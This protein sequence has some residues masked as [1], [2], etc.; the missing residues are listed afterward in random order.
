MNKVKTITTTI[1]WHEHPKLEELEK[2][3]RDKLPWDLPQDFAEKA[4]KDCES[5]NEF[6]Y[7]AIRWIGEQ[8]VLLTE[9]NKMIDGLPDSY[10]A[11]IEVD[12]DGT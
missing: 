6:K 3:V 8:I 5:L 1:E 11:M 2:W 4:Y 10:A 9:L 7:T 12:E